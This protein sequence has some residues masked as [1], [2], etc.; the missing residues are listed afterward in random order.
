MDIFD[1]LLGIPV[2]IG[3]LAERVFSSFMMAS[4]IRNLQ[5]EIREFKK[6]QE[7]SDEIIIS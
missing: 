7:V 4:H 2:V 6:P 3:V 5:A 1:F